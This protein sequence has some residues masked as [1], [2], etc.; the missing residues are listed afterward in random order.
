MSAQKPEYSVRV[1][2]GL[3]VMRCKGAQTGESVT[4]MREEIEAILFREGG[5]QDVLVIPEGAGKPT[6]DMM[7]VAIRAL[8]EVPLS[9]VAV[10]TGIPRRIASTNAIL[11]AS[12]QSE[13]LKVFRHEE[14]ARAWL[15]EAIP[16]TSG[17]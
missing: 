4:A 7:R 8:R 5:P 11:K 6:V 10:A 2:G 15:T 17:K 3:I 9:R 1:E 14:D 13:R 16:Q 12:G